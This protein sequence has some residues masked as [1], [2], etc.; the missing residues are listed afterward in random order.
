M[1]RSSGRGLGAATQQ[2]TG[3]A[4]AERG[5]GDSH[6]PPSVLERLSAERSL[7]HGHDLGHPFRALFHAH[8]EHVEF[9]LDVT[10]A[11]DDVD[12][13]LAKIV[14]NTEILGN[15]QW[16]VKRCD[17]RTNDES[18]LPRALRHGCNDHRR[19]RYVAV[20]HTVVLGHNDVTAPKAI[21][22]LCH[23]QRSCVPVSHTGTCESRIAEIKPKGKMHWIIHLRGGESIEPRKKAIERGSP[24]C[25]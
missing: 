1:R 13:P 9:F 5:R 25:R 15:S 22:P 20:T 19:A 12:T 14:E 7:E 4:R 6:R 21:S 23:F 17:Q 8:T 2:Y 10:G 24:L 11:H 18:N 3:T 16:I